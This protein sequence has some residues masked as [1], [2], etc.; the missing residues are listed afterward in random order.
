MLER[1]AHVD[2][3]LLVSID[4]MNHSEADFQDTHGWAPRGEPAPKQ[5][6]SLGGI[7]YS[8]HA[9]LGPFGFIS[10]EIF[11]GSVTQFEVDNFLH[12]HLEPLLPPESY[13]IIDNAS[14]KKTLLVYDR[15]NN[16]FEGHFN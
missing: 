12:Y 1:V 10:W 2:P 14:N 3:D 5:K 6:I 15:L 9:A 8:I 11:V 4:G 16:M 13:G 7:S